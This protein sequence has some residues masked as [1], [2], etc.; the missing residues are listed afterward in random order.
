M[1]F[2]I[3]INMPLLSLILNG[4]VLTNVIYVDQVEKYSIIPPFIT[5]FFLI[6]KNLPI[7]HKMEISRTLKRLNIG[8]LS[9]VFIL[10]ILTET[11]LDPILQKNILLSHLELIYF[12]CRRDQDYAQEIFTKSNSSEFL[13]QIMLYSDYSTFSYP[14]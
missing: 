5:E 4:E 1:Q 3:N 2:M 6:V 11:D 14:Y 12:T 10:G 13:D 7:D 9:I 8:Y